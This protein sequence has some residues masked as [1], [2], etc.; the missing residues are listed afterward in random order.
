ME[1]TPAQQTVWNAIIRLWRRESHFPPQHALCAELGFRNATVR[2][3]LEALEKKGLIVRRSLG[4]GRSPQLEFSPRGRRKAG[5]I[6]LPV[7]GAIAAGSL[8]DAVQEPV[9]YLSVP[10]KP[11]WFGLRVRGDSMAELINDGD[12]VILQS[13]TEPRPGEICAVRVDGEV[14]LK[15][16]DWRDAKATLRPHNASFNAIKLP[17]ERVIVDGV[18]RGLVRGELAELM[19]EATM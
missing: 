7:I 9:G 16:L 3:H 13:E 8:G 1:L 17:L 4:V 15:Y 12:I 11:G 6:G 5:L 18:Y 10:G 14:T 2:Q 19:M